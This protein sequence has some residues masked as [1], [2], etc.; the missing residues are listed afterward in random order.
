MRFFMANPMTEY[1]I[2]VAKNRAQSVRL[3]QKRGF[4]DLLHAGRSR[5]ELNQ[6]ATKPRRMRVLARFLPRHSP[7]MIRQS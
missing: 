3:N 6:L 1:K 2:M 4:L 7:G 5:K